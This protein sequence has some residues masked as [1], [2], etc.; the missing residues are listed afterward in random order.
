LHVVSPRNRTAA[1]PQPFLIDPPEVWMKMLIGAAAL[2]LAFALPVSA[3]AQADAQPSPFKALEVA[4]ELQLSAEQRA[5]I[6]VARDSLREAHR[7]HCAPMHASTPSEANEAKHHAEM[8]LINA[9]WEGAARGAMTPVQLTRLAELRPVQPAAGAHGGDHHQAA[10]AA[11]GHGGHHG[12]QPA[13]AAAGHGGH[14]GAQPAP[15]AA[16]HSGHHG[17][18]PAPAAAPAAKPAEGHTHPSR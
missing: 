5:S 3:S 7:I 2:A 11:A 16:G 8:A 14:H 12:A 4:E 18:H 15:A 1:V 10:P 17:A 6:T 9:R 13:P